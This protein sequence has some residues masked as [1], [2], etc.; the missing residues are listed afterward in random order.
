[1]NKYFLGIAIILAVIFVSG[2]ISAD[3]NSVS[4]NSNS[5]SNNDY[6]ANYEIVELSLDRNPI[7]L[8]LNETECIVNGTTEAENITI[9]CPDL[10]ISNLTVDVKNGTF[11]YE[12]KDIPK[13]KIDIYKNYTSKDAGNKRS[14]TFDIA[15]LEIIAEST[16]SSIH[17]HISNVDIKRVISSSEIEKDFKSSCK[18]I[19]FDELVK[20]NPYNFLGVPAKYSGEIINTK[21]LSPYPEPKGFELAVDGDRNKKIYFYYN[22]T[23]KFEEG[24]NITVWCEISGDRIYGPKELSSG[25]AYSGSSVDYG[26]Y[27]GYGYSV[28]GLGG[29]DLRG[30]DPYYSDYYTSINGYTFNPDAHVWYF[31]I[32]N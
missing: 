7:T 17:K 25:L 27:R 29:F 24:D 10:N 6:S 22:G 13:S 2:C 11:Y 12:L 15:K 8:S 14:L 5:N 18:D 19:S 21:P 20:V 1:M 9:N 3:S 26:G 16:N 30:V 4:Q 32:N 23:E 31:E 28:G